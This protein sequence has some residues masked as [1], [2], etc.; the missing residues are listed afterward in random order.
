MTEIRKIAKLNLKKKR[1]FKLYRKAGQQ[2]FFY[3]QEVRKA[4]KIKMLMNLKCLIENVSFVRI[5]KRF[6]LYSGSL[7]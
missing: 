4:I 6:K 7:L 2:N 3:G 5:E 1:K